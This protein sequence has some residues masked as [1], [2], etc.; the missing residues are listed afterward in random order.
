MKARIFVVVVALVAGTF[1]VGCASSKHA[2]P[3]SAPQSTGH[4]TGAHSIAELIDAVAASPDRF[5]FFVDTKM[6]S[7]TGPQMAERLRQRFERAGSPDLTIEHWIDRFGTYANGQS[8]LYHV[9]ELGGVHVELRQWL[10]SRI[11][12]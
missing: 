10:R 12:R 5:D 9:R 3:R 2:A 8:G 6:T 11:A 4:T 1:V 7:L